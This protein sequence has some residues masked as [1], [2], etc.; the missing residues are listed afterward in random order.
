MISCNECGVVL[1]LLLCCL[2]RA[3]ECEEGS[4]DWKDPVPVFYLPWLRESRGAV[5]L[6][7]RCAL[8]PCNES[9][10]DWSAAVWASNHT[11]HHC[12]LTGV[13]W[14]SA[15]VKY[16]NAFRGRNINVCGTH[17]VRKRS[18][19]SVKVGTNPPLI[20]INVYYISVLSLEKVPYFRWKEIHFIFQLIMRS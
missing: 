11:V 6:P 7:V 15:V 4:S 17:H 20:I 19:T 14:W 16:S 18:P 9:T 3:A 2:P 1:V 13:L 10:I 12:Q 5:L 8:L